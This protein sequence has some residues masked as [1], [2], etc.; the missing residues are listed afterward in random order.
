MVVKTSKELNVSGAIGPCISMKLKNNHVSDNEIGVGL[1]A[2]WKFCVL[3]PSTTCAFYFDIVQTQTS[4]QNMQQPN[5]GY[6]QFITQYQG[7]DGFRHVRVTT[8][9][10]NFGENDYAF[11]QEVACVLMA[12]LACH[13]A[14]EENNGLFIF[15]IIIYLFS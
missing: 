15:L 1:T 6:I 12:R 13:R 8:V 2:Q 11:D 4:Q 5:R 3:K 7:S 9:S 10:R 14:Q